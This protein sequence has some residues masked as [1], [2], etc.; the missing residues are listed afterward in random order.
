M[1]T[2]QRPLAPPHILLEALAG[3]ELCSCDRASGGSPL[4]VAMTPTTSASDKHDISNSRYLDAS[5]AW[6]DV[7]SRCRRLTAGEQMQNW[8]TANPA[9]ARRT[10]C[11]DHR[12]RARTA[13]REQH[14]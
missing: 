1:K 5:A 10:R 14:A 6:T 4:A 13:D 7:H 2:S 12:S 11:A 3:H 9:A 8:R